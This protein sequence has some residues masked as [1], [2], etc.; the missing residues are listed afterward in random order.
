MTKAEKTPY[1]PKE[2]IHWLAAGHRAQFGTQPTPATLKTAYAQCAHETAD[3]R[4]LWGHNVANIACFGKAS[5][6]WRGESSCQTLPTQPPRTF[7]LYTAIAGSLAQ[8]AG[9]ADYWRLLAARYPAALAAF[10]AGEPEA[11]AAALKAGGFYEAPLGVYAA[12]MRAFFDRAP[13]PPPTEPPPAAGA[14]SPLAAAAIVGGALWLLARE[15]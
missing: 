15:L 11:A 10:A 6:W 1:T 8:V 7:R 4:A 2:L 9:A 14:A 3:G 5:K 13:A 12:A